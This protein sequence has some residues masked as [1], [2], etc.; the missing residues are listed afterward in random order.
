MIMFQINVKFVTTG[1]PRIDGGPCPCIEYR[2]FLFIPPFFTWYSQSIVTVYLYKIDVLSFIRC[3]HFVHCI[4]SLIY[5]F[6]SNSPTPYPSQPFHLPFALR[7]PLPL[8]LTDMRIRFPYSMSL[9][10]TYVISQRHTHTEIYNI[11][12]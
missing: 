5:Y 4:I 10:Q 9:V 1:L 12:V 3:I 6:I 2:F 11:T 8:H 7:T